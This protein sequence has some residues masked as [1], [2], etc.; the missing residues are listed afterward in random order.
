MQAGSIWRFHD[1]NCMAEILLA[2]EMDPQSSPAAILCVLQLPSM[3]RSPLVGKSA[4]PS[5]K[6]LRASSCHVEMLFA[7]AIESQV[8]P[9]VMATDLPVQVGVAVGLATGLTFFL[10]A[11]SFLT[12]M[13][14]LRVVHISCR[15]RKGQG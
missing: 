6:P 4:H 15:C 7:S 14:Y 8:S 3:Q 13:L 5:I 9:D 2:F 10:V 12:W 11:L 1:V